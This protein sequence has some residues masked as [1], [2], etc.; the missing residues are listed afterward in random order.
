MH[1]QKAHLSLLLVVAQRP[2][3]T[4]V[5]VHR[6]GNG[7]G[8]RCFAK[9][10]RRNGAL[11]CK[12]NRRNVCE[13]GNL[14]SG[15]HLLNVEVGLLHVDVVDQGFFNQ[16]LQLRVGEHFAP[17]HAAEIGGVG[18]RKHTI[19]CER[20]AIESFHLGKAFGTL[21]ILVEITAGQQRAGSYNI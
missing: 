3:R 21:V 12:G 5:P 16:P 11:R 6:K 15:F 8:L 19:V 9:V 7:V 18:S 13:L 2:H 4:K 10:E 17:R 20:V 1:L 14:Q